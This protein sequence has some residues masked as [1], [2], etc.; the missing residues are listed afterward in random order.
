MLKWL[1]HKAKIIMNNSIYGY[2]GKGTSRSMSTKDLCSPSEDKVGTCDHT[3]VEKYD[4][5]VFVHDSILTKHKRFQR[6]LCME[7]IGEECKKGHMIL[8]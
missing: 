2:S 5:S 3:D 4:V 1:K 8:L 6:R 7:C